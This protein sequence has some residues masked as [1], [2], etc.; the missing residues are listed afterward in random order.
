[1][2]EK[3]NYVI[4]V[5][6]NVVE[7]SP[8]VYYAY[9]HMERQERGQEEKKRRNAVLSYDAL[10]NGNLT[11]VES[12]PDLTLPSL[13]EQ[14]IT[15][16]IRVKLI[17]NAHAASRV[18]PDVMKRATELANSMAESGDLP[19]DAA[20]LV[21]SHPGFKK[22]LATA[23]NND[24]SRLDSGTIRKAVD[25]FIASS[26]FVEI[27]KAREEEKE[28]ARKAMTEAA[29]K[30]EKDKTELTQTI[31]EKSNELEI[32]RQTIRDNEEKNMRERERQVARLC[33]RAEENARK[34][35]KYV[36]KAL[37]ACVHITGTFFACVC[38]VNVILESIQSISSGG[39]DWLIVVNGIGFFC[40][41]AIFFQRSGWIMRKVNKLADHVYK[42]VYSQIVGDDLV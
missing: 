41:V 4:R 3:E 2:A 37:I 18:L 13:E 21:S 14:V 5:E 22:Y 27:S 35:Q 12:I 7:V 32:L 19:P 24:I 1:M 31:R 9:F 8:E 17:A 33:Q 15:N 28:K 6:G 20:L 10:D 16:E 26:A 30:S 34:M 42:K 38:L 25:N 40:S 29:V 39:F 23:I 36:R 11:G